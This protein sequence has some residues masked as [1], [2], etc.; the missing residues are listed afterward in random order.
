MIATVME[1]FCLAN[2]HSEIFYLIFFKLYGQCYACGTK[3]VLM[4]VV[5]VLHDILQ[6]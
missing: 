4:F 3:N 1:C 6:T 2:F 5:R